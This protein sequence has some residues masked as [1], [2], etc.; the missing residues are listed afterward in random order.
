MI[1]LWPKSQ[2]TCLICGSIPNLHAGINRRNSLHTRMLS[3]KIF[4]YFFPDEFMSNFPPAYPLVSLSTSNLPS[5][6]YL[7]PSSAFPIKYVVDKAWLSK[8]IRCCIFALRRGRN[9]TDILCHAVRGM[10]G[11]MLSCSFVG[12]F[13]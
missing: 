12:L 11:T 13:R 10:L 8:E 9:R 6:Q 2:H 4:V 5:P 1:N 7:V 3:V